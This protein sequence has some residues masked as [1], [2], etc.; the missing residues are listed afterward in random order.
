MERKR[1]AAELIRLT[2]AVVEASTSVHQLGH[3]L[4]NAPG[5]GSARYGRQAGACMAS[6][7]VLKGELL[8]V[9]AVTYRCSQHVVAGRK[10]QAL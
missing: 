3:M 1:A 9:A 6:E 8:G 10:L 4:G 2:E 7:G 5:S